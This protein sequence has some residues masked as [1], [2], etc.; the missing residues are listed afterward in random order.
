MSIISMTQHHIS[1]AD[2]QRYHYAKSINDFLSEDDIYSA[3]YEYD[4][5]PDND[6]F[7]NMQ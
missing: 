7:D 6:R 2:I 5:V 4:M 3:M 1:P